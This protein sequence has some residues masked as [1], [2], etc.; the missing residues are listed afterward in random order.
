M[1]FWRQIKRKI[2]FGGNVK[3]KQDLSN[4]RNLKLW[5]LLKP[6]NKNCGIKESGINQERKST[7]GNTVYN[8]LLAFCLLMKVLVDFLGQ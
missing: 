2:N 1:D 3:K 6:K 4:I 7:I 8:L 5:N